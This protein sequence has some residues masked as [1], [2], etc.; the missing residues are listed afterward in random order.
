MPSTKWTKANLEERLRPYRGQHDPA[1]PQGKKRARI[2]RAA[3]QLFL[4]HGYR[5]TSIDE[6][7][8]RAH[9]AKGT[10]YLYFPDKATLLLHSV[11][12][13]RMVLLGRFEPLVTGAIPERERLRYWLVLMLTS[14]RDCPLTTRL[15]TG[16]A[17]LET[18]L[19]DLGEE[20]VRRNREEG[21]QWLVELIE[22][23][24]PGALTADEKAARADVLM[25]LGYITPRL[26][27]EEA[28]GGRSVDELAE[29]LADMLI[30]GTAVQPKGKR[31]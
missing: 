24:S 30:H 4:A 29:T 5:R 14:Q 21:R 20:F 3:T 7:A 26:A 23:A 1:S 10:V 9:V 6:V 12:A 19:E 18:A 8:R 11:A 22:L 16:D 25:V 31:R 13:E 27:H 28:H 2:L 15:L 17:E